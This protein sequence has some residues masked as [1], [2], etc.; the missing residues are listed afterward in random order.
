MNLIEKIEQ[1]KKEFLPVQ[2]ARKDVSISTSFTFRDV[3]LDEIRKY[4]ELHKLEP[5]N[6]P[7]C[8][9]FCHADLANDM[10][11]VAWSKV[12]KKTV[13]IDQFEKYRELTEVK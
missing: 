8:I 2:Q 4:C 7:E 9:G 5:I 1:L 10:T 12:L 3:P 13:R 6:R 11:F